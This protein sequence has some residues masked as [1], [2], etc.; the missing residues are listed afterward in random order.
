MKYLIPPYP[1]GEERTY[2]LYLVG[3][4]RYWRNAILPLI[5]D[6]LTTYRDGWID[7]LAGAFRNLW[8]VQA[9]QLQRQA[10][11]VLDRIDNRHR[12]W[13]NQAQGRIRG[14]PP[15][16][17]EAITPEPWRNSE[18]DARLAANVRLIKDIGEKAAGQVEEIIRDG[19]R[20]G[21]ST[22]EIG[23]QVQAS[24]DSAE[25]R[26][27]NIARDQVGK[28]LGV[29][30]EHRQRDAGVTRYRWRT[31]G[32]SRVRDSHAV[33]EGKVFSW[34]DP[35]RGG[36]PGQAVNCRCVAEA[37]LDSMSIDSVAAPRHPRQPRPNRTSVL[38]RQLPLIKQYYPGRHLGLHDFEQI[39]LTP[40]Y[41]T[42][43]SPELSFWFDDAGKPIGSKRG[44]PDKI[45]YT[46]NEK[47]HMRGR[48]LT[49]SHSEGFGI[50][51]QDIV[52]AVLNA[53]LKEIRAIGILD[54]IKIGPTRYGYS[55]ERDGD[56]W[57]YKNGQPVG[58]EFMDFVRDSADFH[59]KHLRKLAKLSR[60][61]I[62]KMGD[63]FLNSA[64][65]SVAY[66]VQQVLQCKYK[67]F[68]V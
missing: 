28:H 59:M 61:S 45:I 8:E 33:R 40:N 35:P 58:P 5:K 26:A 18:I 11:G 22:K 39:L 55:L 68:E 16:T 47:K 25:K 36:N 20:S 53:D 42:P 3:A 46:K 12:R 52:Y 54:D 1:L 6:S 27:R 34:D 66:D 41:A 15:E 56:F 31:A 21:R 51:P 13:W 60:Q 4:V 23:K 63:E 17:I 62:R 65:E 48:R 38:H 64:Y 9:Q 30:N 14:I 50:S 44:R 2:A 7:N 19:V 57:R 32:D 24:L 67:R 49:H 37:D 10:R 43:G 29:L